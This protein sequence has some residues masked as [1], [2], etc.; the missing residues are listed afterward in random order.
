MRMLKAIE[1]LFDVISGR[2]G[3]RADACYLCHRSLDVHHCNWCTLQ[4]P[5]SIS[6]SVHSERDGREQH[7]GDQADAD[8]SP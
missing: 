3:T 4:M 7:G 2:I 6:P 8:V 1:N 5:V